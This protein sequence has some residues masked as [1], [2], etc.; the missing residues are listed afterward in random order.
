MDTSDLRKRI[1]RALDDARKDATARRQVVDAAAAAYQQFLDNTAAPLVR[2][3][4]TVL[5][6]ENHQFTANTPAGSV[7]LVSDA[8]PQTFLEF[9][10][11]V[12]GREP[13]VIG[14]VSLARGRQGV[15][16]EERPIAP[17]KATQDL[18]DDD[19][20]KFLVAE[21]PRLILK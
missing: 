16:V 5:R 8:A 21:I 11:D 4:V 13:Q 10:L 3:A 1:L 12:T 7:R 9:E 19:V 17:G 2:Q 15:V 20:A 18:G 14:R 6:A